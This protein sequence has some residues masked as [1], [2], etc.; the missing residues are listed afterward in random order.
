MGVQ[1]KSDVNLIRHAYVST[2]NRNTGIGGKLLLHLIGKSDK[3]VLIGTW[4]A[5]TWAIAFYQKHGFKLVTPEEK[6]LLLKKYWKISARQIE[7]SV[8]LADKKYFTGKQI[9]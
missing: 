1:D 7:T 4:E 8:V 9:G 5:A 3:P 6:D 2:V